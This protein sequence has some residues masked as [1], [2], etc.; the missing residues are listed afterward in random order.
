MNFDK[1]RPESWAWWRSGLRYYS[2]G[3]YLRERFAARVHRVSVD[4]GFTCPNVDGTVAVGGCTFCDNRSFSPSRRLPRMAIRSQIDEG[5]S[6]LQ[7]RYP[8]CRKFLA[9]FQPASNTYGPVERLRR[10]YDEAVSHPQIVGLVIGTRPD[11]LP[12]AVIELLAEYAGRTYVSLEI[13]MQ[14]MHDRSL[15]AMNRGHTHAATVDAVRRCRGRGFHIGLHL[16]LGWPGESWQDMMA[17]A[18]EV[19]RL[20]VDAVK[21]HNLYAVRNTPLGEQVLRGEVQL[22]DRD[23]YVA[24]LV[25]FLERLPPG[26]VVERVAGDAPSDYLIGPTWC[27]DKNGV[28]LAIEHEFRTRNTW[29]GRLSG[30]HRNNL[31]SN[32]SP[33]PAI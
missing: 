11:C 33:S 26:I 10:L 6:R 28:R 14:T 23:V 19:A 5:I 17:T 22:M 30:S 3:F 27:L 24:T 29:Q 2:Y 15:L 1:A 13:G 9:Y 18:D 31:R 4:G 20:D 16:I 32:S 21:I 8:D 7:R 25:D 12:E